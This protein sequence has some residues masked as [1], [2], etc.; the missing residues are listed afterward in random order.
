[1][2]VK[3]TIRDPESKSQSTAAQSSIS[4]QVRR[5]LKGDY[6]IFDHIDIDIVVQPSENKITTITKPDATNTDMVYD[7]QNRLF[8]HLT[9]AGVVD[10]ATIEGGSLYGTMEG[11]YYDNDE[12]PNATQVAVFSVGKFIEEERP[13]MI[14]RQAQEEVEIGKYAEPEDEYTT[15][16]GD[17]PHATQ[18]GT[19]YPNDFPSGANYRVYE[20]NMKKEVKQLF[21]EHY[22]KSKK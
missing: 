12:Q 4:L 9:K 21:L 11:T 7:A 20:E 5:N 19:I 1:V 14:F 6:M 2:T 13:F 18:K 17:V 16:L 8:Q 15:D 3:V 10:P 22:K